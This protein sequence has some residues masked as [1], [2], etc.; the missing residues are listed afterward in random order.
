ML[1]KLKSNL[2]EKGIDF[3]ITLPLKEKV[4]ELGYEPAFGAR[5]MRR[6]I[7][8]KIENVLATALLSG[9]VKRGDKLEIN[10]QTFN[11]EINK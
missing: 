7:Q 3:I 6:I 9:E 8:D 5:Q 10:A 2:K 4:V 11:L 1:Q